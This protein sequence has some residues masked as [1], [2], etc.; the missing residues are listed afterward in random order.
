MTKSE[1]GSRL[2]LCLVNC[3]LSAAFQE[4]GHEVLNLQ[5]KPSVCNIET[6]LKEHG[7]EPDA[8]IQQETLGPRILVHGLERLPCPK[9]YWAV[10]PHLNAFWQEEYAG[11]FDVICSTQKLWTRHLQHRGGG[12]TAWLPWYGR[13]MP[14]V[15]WSRRTRE[16]CFIGRVDD[17]RISRQH[18]IA[19]L[20]RRF[21]MEHVQ[22]V[23]HREVLTIY[24]DA[25]IAP[26]ESIFGEINFRLFEATSCGCLVF[27]QS[28]CPGL[29]SLFT[30]GY[31]VV[32]FEHALELEAKI[33][34]SFCAPAMAERTAKA[35]W[36]RVQEAHLP[37][38]RAEH[39]VRLLK[40]FSSTQKVRAGPSSSPQEAWTLTLY[41]LWQAG[42][43]P[44]V[45]GHLK[46]LLLALP[47]TAPKRT[48]LLGFWY[49]S[50]KREALMHDLKAI[51]QNALFS[52]SED[53]NRTASLAA[54]RINA[55]DMA[56]AFFLRYIKKQQ[57]GGRQHT[58]NPR[59]LYL[60]WA[61]DFQRVGR[62]HR[63]GLPFDAKRHLPESAI[64]CLLL[65]QDLWPED[66][67]VCRSLDALLDKQIGLEPLRITLLEKM[68]LQEPGNWLL[69]MKLG[70]VYLRGFRVE[71]GMRALFLANGLAGEQGQEERFNNFLT[72]VDPGG[73]IRGALSF[74][75]AA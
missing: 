39:L 6:L 70:L 18:F 34:K 1:G 44:V 55:L 21:N 66:R 31:E 65:A 28:P 49:F 19:S 45:D 52:E 11:L 57:R 5:P 42:R 35:A 69:G 29:E 68:T 12:R 38:H 37:V 17:H 10:D 56:K 26:N 61:R 9:I 64:E 4:L 3:S 40:D 27:N 14:W 7:F 32:T 74:Y 25:K 62:L 58:Q 73:V 2:R 51:I 30:P 72:A 8:V 16:S 60:F 43:A 46:T 33:S 22:D 47:E 48:A 63:P 24:K 50:G 41:R 36:A 20:Q 75:S 23:P 71:E 15:P 67:S 54:L 53:L 59:D 13:S